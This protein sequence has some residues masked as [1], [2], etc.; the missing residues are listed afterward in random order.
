MKGLKNIE[1]K[2]EERLKAIK[3]KNENIKEVIDFI[4]EPLTLEAKALI[5]EIR[6]IQKYVDYKKLKTISGNKFTY[7]FRDYKRFKELF[8]DI[9]YRNMSINKVE[10]KQDEFDAVL[11]AL[12]KY[13]P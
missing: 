12:S 8:R 1:N 9:Y 11:N 4:D 13:S 6:S 10:R 2:S 3:S 7:D 5:E